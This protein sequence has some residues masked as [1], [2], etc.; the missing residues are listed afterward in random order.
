MDANS[1][2]H[3]SRRLP[4]SIG[5]YTLPHFG[6]KSAKTPL[7]DQATHIFKTAD[8]KAGATA[9]TVKTAD[10]TAENAANLNK[11]PEGEINKLA[12]QASHL[13]PEKYSK[14]KKIA[15]WFGGI[16]FT[17]SFIAFLRSTI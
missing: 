16:F 12:K 17:I 3:P 8:D 2:V 10:D 14:F 7:D 4:V 15:L 9:K 11:N 13:P 6:F 1:Q 5:G